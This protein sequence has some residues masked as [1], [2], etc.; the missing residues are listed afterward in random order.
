MAPIISLA[1]RRLP[2]TLTPSDL[3]DYLQ[4]RFSA[5]NYHFHVWPLVNEF[6]GNTGIASRKCA[7]VAVKV[8]V[9]PLQKL[10]KIIDTLCEDL[11]S[12]PFHYDGQQWRISADKYFHGV[13][14][15]Y[16]HQAGASVE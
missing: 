14:P 11:N 5:P 15:L 10:D 16:E 6:D 12:I 13:V 7:T 4:G 2:L 8:K 9:A 3:R 1:I